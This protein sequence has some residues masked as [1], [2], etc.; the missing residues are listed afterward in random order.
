MKYKLCFIHACSLNNNYLTVYHIPVYSF[1]NSLNICYL[2]KFKYIFINNL[3]LGIILHKI[4][5]IYHWDSEKKTS[6]DLYEI[7][8][9]PGL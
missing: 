8:F 2:Y 6:K 3:Y 5:G 9:P 7:C 4:N 1:G